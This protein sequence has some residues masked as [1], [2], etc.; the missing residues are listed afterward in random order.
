MD[1]LDGG[2][3]NLTGGGVPPLG[4]GPVRIVVRAS[5]ERNPITVAAAERVHVG[6]LMAEGWRWKEFKRERERWGRHE[7]DAPAA[8]L[9]VKS[10]HDTS[11]IAACYLPQRQSTSFVTILKQYIRYGCASCSH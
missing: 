5:D 1:V 7:E 3:R 6:S 2:H 4:Y 9:V 8:R 11:P 10:V